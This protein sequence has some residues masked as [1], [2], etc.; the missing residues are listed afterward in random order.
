MTK[1]GKFEG[2]P[3][4]MIYAVQ[5]RAWINTAV[6]NKWIELVYVPWATAIG[7]PN[8]VLFDIGPAYAKR[9]H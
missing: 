2:F 6:M 3:L 9:D 4:L 5:E 1:D 8:I 7:G